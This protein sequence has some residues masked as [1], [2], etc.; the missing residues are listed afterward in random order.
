M[1]ID[2]VPI[3][4]E[5]VE[6]F[7][8]TVD[9]VA[10]EHRYLAMLQAPPI[11]SMREFFIRGISSGF[12]YFVAVEG[13]RVVGW[14]DITPKE[15]ATMR[16]CGVLGMGLLPEYRGRGLGRP[17]MTRSLDAARA[18]GLA[19]VELTVR[20]DNPRA[21]ALYRKLGFEVEGCNRRAM[22]VDGQFEDLLFMALLFDADGK[23]SD[24]AGKSTS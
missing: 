8:A 9:V 5:H 2:I 22:L 20:V 10:R 16:H 21:L 4:E 18:F 15:R 17:L 19:R 24:A 11:D 1:S 23:V 6:S 3:R 12:P 14:C 13:G 7:H